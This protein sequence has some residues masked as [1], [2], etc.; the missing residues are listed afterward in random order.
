M[1]EPKTV[2]A[3]EIPQVATPTTT[4]GR[5]GLVFGAV[6]VAILAAVVFGQQVSHEFTNWDDNWLVTENRWIRSFDGE[7]LAAVLNPWVDSRV[8]EELGNE[9]LPVR[10]LSSM[11]NYAVHGYDAR[12][13]HLTDLLLHVVVSVL[14]MLLANRLVKIT[15]AAFVVGALFAVMPIHVEVVSWVSCRK[16]LLSAMFGLLAVLSY[17]RWR[18]LDREQEGQAS[19]WWLVAGVGCFVL[20]LFSKVPVITLPG[21]LV[22]I[23]VFLAPRLRPMPLRAKAMAIGAFLAVAVFV[24]AAI[25]YPIASNGLVRE[26]FGGSRLS[27]TFTALASIGDYFLAM[28]V[29][30]PVGPVVD[31]PLRESIDLKVAIGLV[32]GLAALGLVVWMAWKDRAGNVQAHREGRISA[33]ALLGLGVGWVLVALFPVS[34]LVIVTGTAYADRYAYFP[35]VGIC[36]ALIWVLAWAVTAAPKEYRRWV[37]LAPFVL[38][39]WSA[40]LSYRE[41]SVWQSSMTLWNDVLARDPDNHNALFN[42]A[43]VHQQDAAREQS[44]LAQQM[45][46]DKAEADLRAALE[47]PARTFRHDPARVLA[48]IANLRLEMSALA[49][50][51]ADEAAEAASRHRLKAERLEVQT[52]S[53]NSRADR[54]RMLSDAR[55]YR[56]SAE[57]AEARRQKALGESEAHLQEVLTLAVAAR[58]QMGQPWRLKRDHDYI[59]AQISN[60]EGL[61]L[62]RLGKT[63]EAEAKFRAAATLSYRN[64]A[65]FLNLAAML[66]RRGT[67]LANRRGYDEESAKYF[68]EAVQH[69]DDYDRA[70]GY[71]D[72]QSMS[73]RGQVLSKH[74]EAIE[75]PDS[76]EQP[77]EAKRLYSEAAGLFAGAAKM[78]AEMGKALD[79]REWANF[80]TLEAEMHGRI[81]GEEGKALE[82][83]KEVAKAGGDTSKAELRQAQLLLQ[84]GKS[85]EALRLLSDLATR[86]PGEPGVRREL[87]AVLSSIADGRYKALIDLWMGE[88]RELATPVGGGKIDHYLVIAKFFDTPKFREALDKVTAAFERALSYAEPDSESAKLGAAYFTTMGHALFSIGELGACEPLLR[89]SYALHPELQLTSELLAAVYFT[90]LEDLMRRGEDAAKAGQEN[91]VDEVRK[92]MWDLITNLVVVSPRASELLAAQLVRKANEFRVALEDKYVLRESG[93]GFDPSTGEKTAREWVPDDLLPAYSREME[94]VVRLYELAR[95][96]DPGQRNALTHLNDFYGKTGQFEQSVATYEALEVTFKDRPADALAVRRS[97]ASLLTAWALQLESKYRLALKGEKDDE[98]RALRAETLRVL[99]RAEGAWS[100]ALE[101]APARPGRD[102]LS[103]VGGVLQKL[104]VLDLRNAPTY[105]AKAVDTYKL[106]GEEFA[107]E[108]MSVNRKRALYAR[109]DAERMEYL[110]AAMDAATTQESKEEIALLILESESKGMIEVASELLSKGDFAGALRSI[111]DSKQTTPAARLIKGRALDALGR[112]AEAAELLFSCLGDA[113]AQERAAEIFMKENTP[114]ALG[115]AGSAL[116]QALLLHAEAMVE[117]AA[118]EEDLGPVRARAKKAEAAMEVIREESAKLV[119]QARDTRSFTRKSALLRDATEVAPTNF[120]A[121]AMLARELRQW[122]VIMLAEAKSKGDAGDR[123]GE[124]VTR[125]EAINAFDEA[126]ERWLRVILLDPPFGISFRLEQLDLMVTESIPLREGKSREGMLQEAGRMMRSLEMLLS[127]RE[128]VAADDPAL[129]RQRKFLSTLKQT[130]AALGGR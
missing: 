31:A 107:F 104:A 18:G 55:E 4:Q 33:T 30:M 102:L 22:L 37:M 20:A 38:L 119:Q 109:T 39:V 52:G 128:R 65:A 67:E 72:R 43:L 61:A 93:T 26:P 87:A 114:K 124:A 73:Y 68:R 111:E 78:A 23:E 25:A 64:P 58:G 16:D 106:A 29:G 9:Y 49:K 15:L 3:T 51:R 79:L 42:R 10:D 21:L 44:P 108:L 112:G 19:H 84:T 74:A 94:P 59:E 41:V 117:L 14:V 13:W 28:L 92:E 82:S 62:D 45:G 48:A 57:A 53:S 34:N 40:V 95:T 6:L 60:T 121:H 130:Y 35:S 8:R 98:A 110:R 75:G 11:V 86:Y 122:G 56:E 85:D 69:I 90:L 83:V 89:K 103:S 118:R 127:E 88:Y 105:L 120:E 66:A 63:V 129:E 7:N 54:D 99:Q 96:L 100:R 36:I 76:R 81:P 46:L 12:W 115:L 80:K 17:L 47:R 97:L 1:A 101:L 77:V 2:S 126:A 5:R 24:F 125:R 91:V 113:A 70:R 32:V 71:V 123:E 27:N 50:T 116:R